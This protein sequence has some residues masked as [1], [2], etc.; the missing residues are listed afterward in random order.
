[1][2]DRSGMKKNI[3]FLSLLLLVA[4]CAAHPLQKGIDAFDQ[5][6]YDTAAYYW[7]PLAMQ[8]D[9]YAQYNLGLLWES[10]L[11]ATPMDKETASRWYLLSASQGYV[12]AMIRYARIQKESGNLDEALPWLNH[13]ARWG[14]G[15]AVTMLH[16]LDRPVPEP[17]LSA[18]KRTGERI[19]RQQKNVSMP[20]I[21][22]YD[23]SY[24]MVGFLTKKIYLHENGRLSIADD[25]SLPELPTFEKSYYEEDRN[26]TWPGMDHSPLSDESTATVL[27]SEG[28]R[29]FMGRDFF[30]KFFSGD[31][32]QAEPGAE[33]TMVEDAG[34]EKKPGVAEEPIEELRVED[35]EFKIRTPEIMEEPITESEPGPQPADSKEISAEQSGRTGIGET[36]R[37]FFSRIRKAN[38]FKK[39]ADF[40]KEPE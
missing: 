8:G 11:G 16:E 6:N 27:P 1:M 28:S 5:G 26:R 18:K 39:D 23:V 20:G 33:E 31:G 9:M 22:T 12:D 3:V 30:K 37:D 15:E 13:A 2:T 25:P 35:D 40:E 10:G 24:W 29:W 21:H 38:P 36:L 4:G 14:S 7:N 17:D 19:V 32:H 34:V